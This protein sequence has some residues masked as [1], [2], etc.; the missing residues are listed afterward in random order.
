MELD[1]IQVAAEATVGQG[2]VRHWRKCK[3]TKNT[4]F[5]TNMF[6]SVKQQ[7]WPQK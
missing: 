6:V 2:S 4:K 1:K 3:F 5:F 7:C